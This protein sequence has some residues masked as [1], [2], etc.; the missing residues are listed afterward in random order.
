MRVIVEQI[1]AQIDSSQEEIFEMAKARLKKARAF[2]N[3]KSLY[4]YK[5]SIDARKKSDIKL[6]YSVAAEVDAA[7]KLNV[8]ALNSLGIKLS[9]ELTL[10]FKQSGEKQEKPPLIVGFGP[11]GMF[12]ALA[13]ARA[14]LNPVVIE[15]G[16][17]VDTRVLCVEK[18]HK[19]CLCTRC[20]LD[21]AQL[22][23]FLGVNKVFI[24]HF[25]ILQPQTRT[26]T[27]SSELCR[28]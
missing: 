12:C 28:L 4:I 15:R 17:D 27:D 8:E 10:E 5:K 11:A 6:V 24:V 22:N 20:S 3:F 7:S 9:P 26:F 16:A 23:G 18:F 19:A 25:Q 1:K 14:G 21:S 13:L 2:S